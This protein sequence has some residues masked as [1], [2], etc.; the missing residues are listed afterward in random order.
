QTAGAERA[1]VRA[2]VEQ[3]L[4]LALRDVGEELLAC[5]A[6]A[7]P[8]VIL[9]RGIG[10]RG[11]ERNDDHHDH[12]LAQGEAGMAF[13]DAASLFR[14]LYQNVRRRA[15]SVPPGGAGTSVPEI[16]PWYCLPLRSTTTGTG[17]GG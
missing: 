10:D 5:R 4:L 17:D 11:K 16:T 1:S 2:L 7:A 14:F 15:P 12:D 3:V 6:M 13:H 8:D 9:V